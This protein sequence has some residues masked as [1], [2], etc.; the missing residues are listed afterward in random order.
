MVNLEYVNKQLYK[1]C[2]K[3][4]TKWNDPTAISADMAIRLGNENFEPLIHKLSITNVNGVDVSFDD[5][6]NWNTQL[7]ETEMYD[8]TST[9]EFN[10]LYTAISNYKF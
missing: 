1:W 10:E 7:L 3:H 6:D 2:D 8:R 4:Y 5:F 9:E